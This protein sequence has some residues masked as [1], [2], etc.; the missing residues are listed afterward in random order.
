MS[1]KRSILK[2]TLIL[3]A[4]GL[5]TRFIGFFFRIFMSQ[6][7]GEENVGLYQL[8]FPIY[9]LCFSFTTAGIETAIARCVARKVS[10]GKPEEAK[11]LLYVG[12]SI[13][14]TLSCLILCILQC[15]ATMLSIHILGDIRCEPLLIMISY[16]LPFA[17]IH[18][19]ICGYYL[20]LKQTK[21]PA[22]SQLVEQLVR[23]AT[24]YLLCT[25]VR[26]TNGKMS[27]LLAVI[28]LVLGEIASSL[29]CLK[30]FLPKN[31]KLRHPLQNMKHDSI[32]LLTLAIPLTSNRI[33]L[34]ILQ[35]VEAIS[36]PLR[37]HQYGY[38]SAETL[39]IYGV[40][41]GMALPCILFPSALTNS[42]STMLIPTVAEI[43][44]T[45]EVT[46]L[47]NM[48]KKVAFSC[49]VL[50]FCCLLFFLLLGSF[51]GKVLFHSD[52]AG[53]FIQTLAWICPFLYMNTTLISMINGLGRATISFF[54]N[55]LGL[56]I[57]II[58]VLVFIP[59]IGINGYLWGLLLSQ[60]IVSLISLLYL[61]GYI[62]SSNKR[63]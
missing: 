31:T 43:Q 15:Y 1:K 7:F 30:H 9:A 11:R 17:S 18:S 57:R 6:T 36:I 38:T 48:M 22:G 20:G 16:S 39:S 50:G 3:T 63:H 29:F 25:Y 37:L 53:N 52:L 28:G 26:I 45:R 24:I 4:T 34:N 59:K 14:L 2:G 62:N 10:L 32:E 33:L 41:T 8:I 55:T 21:I 40:L 58:G 42:V 35:S 47:K 49:F 13:S 27:I 12:L 46:S 56:L 60:L 51:A 44:V 61:S 19:C 54:I 23:V 5:I